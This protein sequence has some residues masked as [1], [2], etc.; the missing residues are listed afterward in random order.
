M[1]LLRASWLIIKE[2]AWEAFDHDV[3]SHAAGIAFYTALGLAPTVLLFLAITGFMNGVAKQSLVNE[4][5]ELV[6]KEAADGVELVIENA[7]KNDPQKKSSI[8]STIIGIVTF[9]F[10][11]S[12]V[13]AQLQLALNTVWNVMPRPGAGVWDWVRKRLISMGMV[14]GML[15]LML[16]SLVASTTISLAIPGTEV[17]W[18]VLNIVVSLVVFTFSFGL[19]FKFLP[20]V[21]ITWRDVFSGAL[22]TAV[23]FSL[24]KWAIGLYL[25]HSAVGSAYGVA[26]SLIVTL[27][28][29]YYSAII[30]LFGAEMTQ[31]YA[32]HFGSGIRPDK[33]AV[34]MERAKPI[35]KP[36]PA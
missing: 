17:F 16:A 14:L 31:V 13:F 30:L 8:F 19:I 2:A 18:R 24:G 6:G 1:R 4:V 27:V 10:S 21:K 25:G 5:G 26:G 22:M 34:R 23:L 35:E 12:G 3:M 36:S 29:V 9:L 15:I 28:W 11:A 7:E 32:K 33:H 20:D